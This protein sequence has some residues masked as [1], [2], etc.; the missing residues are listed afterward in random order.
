MARSKNKKGSFKDLWI[1]FWKDER[2]GK[3]AAVSC[4]MISIYLLL[5]C[6]SY[7]FTWT[8]DQDKVLQHSWRILF[9]PR[10]EVS[11]WVG[12]LGALSSHYLFYYGFGIASFLLIPVAV[13]LGFRLLNNRGWYS[14]L[15]FV[16]HTFLIMAFLSMTL[17]FILSANPF[18]FGGA[19]GAR[20]N[21]VLSSF[22]GSLGLGV[23]L[24]F[25]ILGLFIWFINP[26]FQSLQLHTDSGH[27][28]WG[29]IF[30]FKS[31]SDADG[32]AGDKDNNPES[33]FK[34][35]A[36]TGARK[37]IDFGE[38]AE[39]GGLAAT[40]GFQSDELIAE[41]PVSNLS[42][43]I[44][45]SPSPNDFS[46]EPLPRTEPRVQIPSVM[47]VDEDE[48]EP[49][50]LSPYD[51]KADLSTYT[52]PDLELLNNYDDQKFEIDRN[53]LESN[54]NQIIATLQNYKIEIQ[55]IK[56]TIGPTVTLYEIVPAP[57]VRISRIKSLEDDIALSL[58]AQ[59]IRII[60]PIPGRGTI[61]IEVAN[62]NKQIVPLKELLRSE[63]F[64]DPKMELPIA[65]GKNISN[66]VVVADLTKMPHLLIAGATGQGKSVGINTILMSL[67][68]RKHPAE[69]KLVLIDP[70]KVELP[71][72]TEIEKHF[73]AQLP[74]Q[75]EAIITD[76]SK[77]IYTLNSL[78]IE[79]DQR[80]ELLK[81]A[82]T[83]NILEYNDKFIRR[84]LNPEK[85]HKH[86]PY[87]VLIIDEF[88]DLIMTA[89]KE[90]EMP[91]SRL[92]QLARAVGIHLIIATQR[93]SV[94][95]ITGLIKAN[96]PS[97][98][99]FKVTSNIDSR[100][101]LDTGGAERLIGRGD[102]LYS[103]GSDVIRLQ[104]AFVDTPEVE[105]VI[106]S[107]AKQRSYGTPYLLPE[108]KQDDA[109]GEESVLN[110]DEMDDMLAEAA[111]L[112]VQSQHGSTS[113]IQRRLKLGYNRAGR[114]MDQMESLG[115][116]SSS[117]GSKPR[118]VLV[119]NEVELENILSKFKRF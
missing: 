21:Q 12:R 34:N 30:N 45:E 66:E 97:R 40:I 104:C 98:M 48:W 54:K 59:G 69:V 38:S 107:I 76:T 80:Y 73:L 16:T 29:G 15:R 94:K 108:F 86:L 81:M 50:G 95:I 47:E 78:C 11:N 65:L 7:L 84:R 103:V 77:V 1:Q 53:E 60:A 19:F 75:E 118:E 36:P 20:S 110:A 58:S 25:S 99:A 26:S 32:E 72:Y 5:S 6:T 93:P 90:V 102:M 57:G 106:K 55:K 42:L 33:F 91:I 52:F 61:G 114:I 117:E 111:R 9:R 112:V 23:T 10:V 14:F 13:H 116:V 79:M 8:I 3:I 89:G 64:T 31:G 67:L 4:F 74:N 56:A 51:P 17:D 24:I 37:D 83:R 27:I 101:I 39:V 105:R 119:F 35:A 113:M 63:R 85:G 109:N 100:T 68:Y 70:K 115:I 44:D 46:A 41:T 43:E 87:I 88:A 71:I 92:A 82:R 96:F 18:P 22:L 62:K 2:I 28:N 49:E